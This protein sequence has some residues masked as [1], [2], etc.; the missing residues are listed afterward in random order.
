VQAA[1]RALTFGSA[2]ETESSQRRLHPRIDTKA[3]DSEPIFP[4]KALPTL[5]D[6]VRLLKTM[7]LGDPLK[8]MASVG[9]DVA[10]WTAEAT[11]W[12][13]ALTGRLEL[14]LRFGELMTAPWE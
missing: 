5:L 9:L 12:G 10:G 6:Y 8:A 4:G 3:L 11:A 7:G 1:Q 2:P 13:Q 14:G